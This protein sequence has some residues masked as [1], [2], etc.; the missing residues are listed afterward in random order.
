[1]GVHKF[2]QAQSRDTVRRTLSLYKSPKNY[3]KRMPKSKKMI[4]AIS[5]IPLSIETQ[6]K[7]ALMLEELKA[8]NIINPEYYGEGE[9]DATQP[10]KLPGLDPVV[11]APG[12]SCSYNIKQ[13]VGEI[14]EGPKKKEGSCSDVIYQS[15]LEQADLTNPT[16][17]SHDAY[18]KALSRAGLKH[19]R[20]DYREMWSRIETNLAEWILKYPNRVTREFRALLPCDVSSLWMYS[21][22]MA[23]AMS[24][25]VMKE[26]DEAV[27]KIG[28]SADNLNHQYQIMKDIITT[29]NIHIHELANQANH[30]SAALASSVKESEKLA[31]ALSDVALR[32]QELELEDRST[33]SRSKSQSV[34]S[35]PP[36]A[37]ESSVS[38]TRIKKELNASGYYVSDYIEL[39]IN[40]DGIVS[41]VKTL[42]PEVDGLKYLEGKKM[43]AVDMILRAGSSVLISTLRSDPLLFLNLFEM[44]KEECL[45]N[46]KKMFKPYAKCEMKFDYYP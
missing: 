26:M 38:K 24:L 31:L 46:M 34:V 16:F 14:L 33:V 18:Y 19:P 9:M 28:Q 27:V 21:H 42:K 23:F 1:M 25:K 2:V 12:P 6:R 45:N 30:A 29:Q 5:K 40:D 15:L 11:D 41:R 22:G 36:E 10:L 35:K 43:K 7:R 20:P 4:K 44:T 13:R 8:Y 32:V 37:P 17:P 3:G 39:K